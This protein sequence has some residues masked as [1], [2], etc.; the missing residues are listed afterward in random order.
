MKRSQWRACHF[1]ELRGHGGTYFEVN[2]VILSQGCPLLTRPYSTSPIIASFL[3]CFESN[4]HQHLPVFHT[5]NQIPSP[6]SSHTHAYT[7]NLPL[8]LPLSLSM[9]SE[10]ETSH[11]SQVH[12][13]DEDG[14]EEDESTYRPRRGVWSINRVLDPRAKWVQEWNRVFLLVSAAGLFVDPLFFYALSISD[15]CLCLFV[16]GWFAITVTVLRC[17]TDTLHVWNMWLQLK[18]AKRSYA[19]VGEGGKLHN[20]TAGSVA[21]QYLKAKKG[22]FFD[23][24]VILPL[25]QVMFLTSTSSPVS[26]PSSPTQ[27]SSSSSSPF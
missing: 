22:F 11:T 14:E 6:H 21:L 26:S 7:H 5:N 8:S 27:S 18:M 9:A 1:P 15:T 25:P 19:M 24:F 23:L 4:P 17:M 2:L 13:V 12:V 3:D 10:E 16:D 20:S